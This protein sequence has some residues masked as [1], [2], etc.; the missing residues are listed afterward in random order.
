M[1]PFIDL[2]RERKKEEIL[3]FSVN[4]IGF[5]ILTENNMIMSLFS[6]EAK[7]AASKKKK[8]FP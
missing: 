1:I 2:S 5:V 4:L 8:T 6:M 3:L 7:S